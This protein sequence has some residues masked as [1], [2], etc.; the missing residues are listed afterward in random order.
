[1]IVPTS[2]TD[3]APP[4]RGSK[5]LIVLAGAIK[6]W[7]LTTCETCGWV[8]EGTDCRCHRGTPKLHVHWD[9]MEHRR[10]V[11][12]RNYV[13]GALIEA[14]YLTYAPHEAFKGTWDDKAQAVNDA[15]IAAADLM[16]I[17]SPLDTVTDGTDDEADYAKRVGTKTL[18]LP[19]GTPLVVE[20]V[21][22][23]LTG[24]PIGCYAS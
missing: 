18:V 14:G 4:E 5:G 17:L 13:R 6:W 15:A 22:Y 21:K 20:R 1:M 9:S 10:Y 23:A 3:A 12:W 2:D 24:D 16:L 11:G 8:G 19:P 7:W